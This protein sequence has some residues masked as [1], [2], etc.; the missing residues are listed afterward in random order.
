[1]RKQQQILRTVIKP[2][3]EGHKVKVTQV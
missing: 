1:M 2:L 3:N